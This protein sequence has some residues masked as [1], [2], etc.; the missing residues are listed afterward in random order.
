M[1]KIVDREQRKEQIAEAVWRVIRR[2]GVDGASVRQVA[3][4]LGMSLGSLRHYFASQ[5]ELLAYAMRLISERVHKRI[6]SL[7][8]SGDAR[9]HTELAIAELLPLDEERLGEAE[10]WLAFAGKAISDPVIRE[11]S[12]QTHNELYAGFRH[13]IES[14]MSSEQMSGKQDVEYET[15]RLHAMVDGLVLHHVTYPERSMPE[16]MMNIISCHLDRLLS[17]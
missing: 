4:E 9:H 8:R 2:N 3:E 17:I 6:L 1:P 16:Q 11:I 12:Q 14:L 15:R 5:H 13:M 10:V 7:P